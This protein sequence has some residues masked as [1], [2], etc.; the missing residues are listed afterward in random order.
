MIR[1][2]AHGFT[3]IEIVVTLVVLGVVAGFV[4]MPLISMVSSRATIN[5]EIRRNADA[6]FALEKISN[7]IR[8]TGLAVGG[9]NTTNQIT[10]NT[11]Q[12]KLTSDAELVHASSGSV[13]LTDV[14]DFGCSSV[15]SSL[16]L[17]EIS[18][19]IDNEIYN[20]RAYIRGWL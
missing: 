4:G 14:N 10:T 7:E 3:L 15:S 8:F 18:L 19:E 20:S 12:Y 13:M 11:D 9:C 2:H 1:H 5:E 6:V 17:Y 16:D